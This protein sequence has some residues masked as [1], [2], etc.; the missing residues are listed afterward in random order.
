[1]LVTGVI[2][3][4]DIYHLWGVGYRSAFFWEENQTKMSW[5]NSTYQKALLS[6]ADF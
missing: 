5:K 6:P 3:S 1:M 4:A 2:Q